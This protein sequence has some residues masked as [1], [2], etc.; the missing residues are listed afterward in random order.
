MSQIKSTELKG[1]WLIPVWCKQYFP[2][3]VTIYILC[4]FLDQ[5]LASQPITG[6]FLERYTTEL[7]SHRIA[8]P[9]E[10]LQECVQITADLMWSR[11]GSEQAGGVSQDIRY[12]RD[13]SEGD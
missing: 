11:G 10:S 13:V 1:K 3:L 6:N 9:A 7:R 12:A 5:V 8:D 2:S 4:E